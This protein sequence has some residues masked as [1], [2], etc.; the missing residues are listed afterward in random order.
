MTAPTGQTAVEQEASAADEALQLALLYLGAETIQDALAIWQDVPVGATA[1]VAAEWLGHAVALVMSRRGMSRDLAI[2]YYRLVRAL[3]TGKT[4]PDPHDPVPTTV[5]MSQLRFEFDRLVTGA[6]QPAELPAAELPPVTPTED[7]P[8]SLADSEAPEVGPGDDSS[9]GDEAIEIEPF[10]WAAIE[11]ELSDDAADQAEEILAVLGP[12]HQERLTQ[13]ID[14]D[15]PAK[16]VD[17]QRDEVHDKAGIRQASAAEHAVLNGA[18]DTLYVAGG[19]DA[20]VLGW[21]RRS[22]TGTP[23][24]FCAMLISRGPELKDSS[25]NDTRLAQVYSSKKIAGTLTADSASVIA[26]TASVGDKYHLNCHCY[27]VP[28]YSTR[29]FQLDPAYNLN[30][31]YAVLWPQVT[32]NLS[33]D[34]AF[35]AWRNFIDADNRDKEKK[36]TGYL[37]GY[38]TAP[39]TDSPTAT[40]PAA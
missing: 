8:D 31:E 27:A 15:K 10:D 1:E 6:S 36:A 32:K 29:Q 9:D 28:I 5:T 35:R 30:R 25:G 4:V 2:A 26:G 12:I 34:D 33:G 18:R 13:K 40:A 24:G 23:C 38:V 37:A 20:R 21:V 16:E 22:R 11:D 17:A 19:R 7:T 3:R 14:T 39:R